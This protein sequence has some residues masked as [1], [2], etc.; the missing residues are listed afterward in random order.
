M[1]DI[2]GGSSAGGVFTEGPMDLFGRSTLLFRAEETLIN[3][4]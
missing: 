1:D 2:D 4:G 3:G